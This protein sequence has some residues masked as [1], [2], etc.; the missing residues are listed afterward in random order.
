MAPPRHE[1][2]CCSAP[3]S[4]LGVVLLGAVSVSPMVVEVANAKLG[5]CAA[6]ACHGKP[7]QANSENEELHTL[8]ET[9]YRGIVSRANYLAQDRPDLQCAVK[10]AARR[11]AKPLASDRS[12]VKRIVRYLVHAPRAV[13]HFPRQDLPA[14]MDVNVDSDCAGKSKGFL[15][16]FSLGFP[17]E[18][19]GFPGEILGFPQDFLR[20][21]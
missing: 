19:P 4:D 2:K 1:T 17:E 18:I 12:L 13:V 20:F 10:G 11:M 21:P 3:S 5:N 14:L 6:S 15:R 9:C 8:E 16:I 7:L